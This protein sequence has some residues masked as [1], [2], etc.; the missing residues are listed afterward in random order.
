[1]VYLNL[2]LPT[3]ESEAFLHAS[4]EQ[5]ATWLLLMAYCAKQ[6]N[7]GVIKGAKQW[8][9]ATW[10]LVIRADTP[11]ESS[12]LWTWKGDN[13]V[14]LHYPQKQEFIIQHRRAIAHNASKKRWRKQ[15]S[16]SL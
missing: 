1:M 10:F 15:R 13:L 3:L 2:H 14:V 6:E 12:T 11:H 8:A 5:I 16:T 7:G 4:R 9:P